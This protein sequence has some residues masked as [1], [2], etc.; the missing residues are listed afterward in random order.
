MLNAIMHVNKRLIVL[1]L[2]GLAGCI[3]HFSTKTTL[4]IEP[5]EKPNTLLPIDSVFLDSVWY[6]YSHPDTVN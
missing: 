3:I 4:D 6:N 2:I 1:L 5:K